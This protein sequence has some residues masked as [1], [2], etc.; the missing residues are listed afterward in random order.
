LI[1]DWWWDKGKLLLLA[2]AQGGLY[3]QFEVRPKTTKHGN[4]NFGNK[5]VFSTNY[6][7]D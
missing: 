4:W 6:K 7:Y 3:D 5:L 1:Y 2:E